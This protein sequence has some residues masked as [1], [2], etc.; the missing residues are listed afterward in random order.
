MKRLVILACLWPALLVAQQQTVG[1][2][3]FIA[4]TSQAAAP[5]FSPAAGAVS[6]PTTVTCSSTTPGSSSYIYMDTS[7]P[8]T[9]NQNTYSVTTAVTLYC[10]VHGLPGYTDSSVSSASYTIATTPSIVHT[11]NCSASPCTV[12]ST[13]AGNMLLV[14]GEISSSTNTGDVTAVSGNGS[15]SFTHATSCNYYANGVQAIDAWYKTSITGGDTSITVTATHAIANFVIYEVAHANTYSAC[16][17]TTSSSTATTASGPAYV[18]S[19]TKLFL[20]EGMNGT[21]GDSVS[22]SSLPASSNWTAAT[23]SSIYNGS[24]IISATNTYQFVTSN[25][26]GGSAKWDGVAIVFSN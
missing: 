14:F 11:T 19:T 8:P 21:K 17:T 22:A 5:T 7:N 18:A 20:V 3:R 4:A 10:Y 23:G 16:Q 6:N 13:T 26:S 12:T 9:T 1:F 15:G 2:H 24:S 25:H